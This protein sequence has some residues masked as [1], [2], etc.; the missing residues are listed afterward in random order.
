[1]VFLLLL[2]LFSFSLTSFSAFS[3]ELSASLQT[4]EHQPEIQLHNPLRPRIM[5]Q[6]QKW[7][8]TAYLFGGTTHYGVDCSSLMQHLFLGAANLSLPRTTGEQIHRGIPV[9]EFNLRA[10]D[11]I[12]FRTGANRRHVGLYIGDNQFIHASS[13]EGVTVSMLGTYWQSRYIT[14]RRVTGYTV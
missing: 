1:M 10:G 11:L 12:F 5:A 14:A 7:K 13:S 3:F 2:S 9:S 6:Y 4:S 8:G